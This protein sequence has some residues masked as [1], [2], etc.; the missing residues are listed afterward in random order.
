MAERHGPWQRPGYR[1]DDIYPPFAC[2]DGM[3][4]G[5]VNI[6][7]TRQLVHDLLWSVVGGGW[8]RAVSD[9]GEQCCTA[10]DYARFLHDLLD[11]R[12]E[13]GRLLLTFA[14]AEKAEADK[15]EAAVSKHFAEVHPNEEVCD[16]ETG[17]YR[18]W[19]EDP[20]LSEPV[21]AQLRR[22]LDVLTDDSP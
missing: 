1:G 12:G 8:E 13:F 20:E 9:Y 21:V 4:A 14:A 7:N 10:D 2:D 11:V 22:C 19:W 3:R 17:V 6:G 16:C 5:G 18:S 15:D